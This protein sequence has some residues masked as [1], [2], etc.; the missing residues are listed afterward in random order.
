MDYA[1][2]CMTGLV[3]VLKTRSCPPL[4]DPSRSGRLLVNVEAIHHLGQTLKH[5]SQRDLPL[6]VSPIH[7]ISKRETINQ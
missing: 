7:S 4:E 2:N 5:E 1:S 6:R 3:L